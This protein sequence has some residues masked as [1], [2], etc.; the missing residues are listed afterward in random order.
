MYKIDLLKAEGIPIRSRPGGIAFACLVIAVPLIVGI[1]MASIYIEH[2]V[3]TS[4]QR[5]QLVRLR[6]V[7]TTLAP[8]L[9]TKR[10]LEERRTQG[11]GLLGDVKTALGRH[12]QWS[13]ILATVVESL[14]ET[15]VLTKLQARQNMVQHKI[16]AKNDPEMEIDISVPVRTLD[17]GVCGQDEYAASQAVRSF[18]DRL[19]SSP[20]LEPWLDALTVS[21]ESQTLDGQ[22][23][24]SYELSCVLKPMIE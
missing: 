9:E 7:I 3:A 24:V 13:P 16:R 11:I 21:Q 14:P 20:V 1:A 8:A 19:R 12:A 22:D 4:V 2:R 15:L 6:Q 23:V 18:Q 17:I 10:T 5:Q